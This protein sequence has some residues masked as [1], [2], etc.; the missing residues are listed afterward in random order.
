VPNSDERIERTVQVVFP[1]L[2]VQQTTQNVA[3]LQRLAEA[4]SGHYYRDIPQAE[5]GDDSLPPLGR[6]IPSREETRVVPGTVD[7]DYSRALSGV[8]MAVIATALACEWITRRLS[9]LA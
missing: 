4:T 3:L 9:Y 2:E 5:S 1:Q 8:L 6:A 7:L